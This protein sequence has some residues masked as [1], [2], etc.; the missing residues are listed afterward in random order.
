MRTELIAHI[1]Q[2]DEETR[3]YMRVLYEDVIARIAMLGEEAGR[4]NARGVPA[5][6]VGHVMI[7]SLWS[8]KANNGT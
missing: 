4:A 1:E 7:A 8:R 2:G 3:R 5:N 6:T